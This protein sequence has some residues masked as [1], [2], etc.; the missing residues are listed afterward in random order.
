MLWFEGEKREAQMRFPFFCFSAR[1][2]N[3]FL[4]IVAV[5]GRGEI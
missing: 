1:G 2:K 4:V 3:S 5:C